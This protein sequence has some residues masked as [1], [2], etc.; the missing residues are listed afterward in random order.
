VWPFWTLVI[1]FFS[2]VWCLD[3]GAFAQTAT[4]GAGTGFIMTQYHDPPNETRL[5]SQITGSEFQPQAAGSY[6]IKNMRLELYDEKGAK[7][8]TMEAPECT[9]DGAKQSL[10]STGHVKI[11]TGDGQFATEGDGFFWKQGGASVIISN[12][13]DTRIRNVNLKR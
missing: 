8:M 5:K 1:W 13:V 7:Q 11:I 3:F 9:Y 12:Q 10:H 6:L 2:G 4:I